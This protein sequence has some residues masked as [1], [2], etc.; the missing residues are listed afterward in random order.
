MNKTLIDKLKEI[1]LN[2]KISTFY[3]K[4]KHK[5]ITY[6]FSEYLFNHNLLNLIN[7]INKTKNKEQLDDLLK[8][9]I[10][11]YSKYNMVNISLLL[12]NTTNIYN[13]YLDSVSIN[14]AKI[15][16]NNNID[17]SNHK[18]IINKYKSIIL[19]YINN[20]NDLKNSFKLDNNSLNIINEDFIN[21]LIDKMFIENSNLS[22]DEKN[23]VK[24]L[25]KIFLNLESIYS[26][27]TLLTNYDFVKYEI[28]NNYFKKYIS[29]LQD[30]QNI[31]SLNERIDNYNSYKDLSVSQIEKLNNINLLEKRINNI[32][33]KEKEELLTKLNKIKEESNLIN[34]IDLLEEIY[35]D[36]ER[37]YRIEIINSLYSPSSSIEITNY[38]Q[39]K[40]ALLHAFIRNTNKL[41]NS[42]EEKIKNEIINLR[43]NNDKSNDLTKEEQDILNKKLEYANKVLFN[44]VVV[45]ESANMDIHYTDSTGLRGYVTNTSNQ[46]SA[47]LFSEEALLNMGSCIGIGFDYEGLSEENIAMSSSSY[48]TTNMGLENLEIE[49]EFKELSSPLSE[50]LKSNKNEVV[51][52]RKNLDSVTKSSYVFVSLSGSRYDKELLLKAKKLSEENNMKLVIFNLVEIKKNLNN[53]KVESVIKR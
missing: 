39:L 18:E 44:Q 33:L 51:L 40:P 25:N 49:E 17:L 34:K 16:L 23:N 43:N 46:I 50:L 28:E 11:K 32:S 13:F 31:P 36:Y 20:N 42:Y 47:T 5:N 12:G 26:K 3:N 30:N 35:S 45:E 41:F 6:N 37:L 8:N 48:Q 15:F 52:F 10:E 38:E 22:F 1:I 24:I 21:N 9:N 2:V 4:N 14:T 7:D 19:D 27:E 53:N 29:L